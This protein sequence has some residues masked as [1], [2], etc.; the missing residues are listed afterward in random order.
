MAVF[1][2][3]TSLHAALLAAALSAGATHAQTVVPEGPS[4]ITGGQTEGLVDNAVSGAL[5]ALAAHPTNADILFVG[6]VNGGIWRT[7]DATATDP[8]WENLSDD[9]TTQ[10]I[11]DIVFD[12]AD[13][14]SQTLVAGIG[15]FSSYGRIGGSRDG[16]F[17]TTDLGL[18]W[19]PTGA[20]L[21]TRNVSKLAVHGTQIH[22][23][24][25]FAENFTCGDVGVYRST[26]GGATFDQLNL[27]NSGMPAGVSTAVTARPGVPDTL[28]ASI[29]FADTCDGAANGI[30]RSGNGGATWVKVSDAAV[31]A[32]VTNDSG[33]TEIEFGSDGTVYVASTISGRLAGVFVSRD[34]GASWTGMDLPGTNEPSFIGIHPGGQGGIHF[35]LAV[36]PTDS[37]IVYIG[38]DR[39]P[40]TDDNEFPNAIGAVDFSGRLFRGDSSA[41]S[42]SQW[43]PLTHSG[44]ASFSSPHADSRDMAFAA[45]G[46][47]LET[48]DG[49]IYRR[50]SPRSTSGDWFSLNSNLQVTEAHDTAYDSLADIVI[51]GNQDTGTSEQE[52][53]GNIVWRALQNGDGGDVAVDTESRAAFSESIRYSS[54][55]FL[56]AFRKRTYDINNVLLSTDFPD[57]IVISGGD[58][59]GQFKTPVVINQVNADRIIF[60]ADNGVYESLDQGDTIS[61][62]GPGIRINQLGGRAVGYG[63]AGNEDI[64]Y[65]GAGEFIF[66]RT[67]PGG[68][69]SALG[70]P[71]GTTIVDIALDPDDPTHVFYVDA[72]DV[73][74][75]DNSGDSFAPVTGDL[76]A[77][78][79]GRLRALA[80]APGA[81]DDALFVGGNRGVYA[82]TSA[83]G[84]STWVPFGADVPSTPVYEFDYDAVS[85][86]LIIGTLGRGTFSVA[87]ALASLTEVDSD[88][89][90]VPDSADNCT[91]IANADQRDSNGDG[92]GNVCDADI[93]NDGLINAIDLG[94]LR[95][96][97]FTTDADADFNGDGIV[98]AIDL[99]VLKNAFFGAPGPSGLAP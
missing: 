47:L 40:L 57:L 83:D 51:T 63:A 78:G 37:D 84:F 82:S 33:L 48:D 11:G 97:F 27:A 68:P 95:L 80:F 70:L 19:T 96:V 30:Y 10:S 60:G 66:R 7:L 24:I 98:N 99:G 92:F 65:V 77:A 9:F 36:D 20:D 62:I 93:S 56:G 69:L 94:L 21:I 8:A 15:L 17:R 45:D 29:I 34:D 54:F 59:F 42:G 81:T 72:N 26:D 31:D 55:Q 49:G 90:G 1:S 89:D 5:N 25:N 67:A 38:G 85:D 91:L 12:T 52:F 88:G 13:A 35:S 58:F 64:L 6:S 71:T 18:T 74:R 23:A 61:E 4:P 76:D 46:N 32:T 28:Y 75:S 43:T 87:N 79:V 2:P 86:T 41:P 53:S 44:T 22:A 14:S 73:Y 3:R 16:L 50:T 39:Q